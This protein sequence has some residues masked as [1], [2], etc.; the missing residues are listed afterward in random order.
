MNDD[1]EAEQFE[2]ELECDDEHL[3][4]QVD[5]TMQYHICTVPHQSTYSAGTSMCSTCS[6]LLGLSITSG[7]M[8]DPGS[9]T[10]AACAHFL[11][12]IMHKSS[13]MQR[14]HVQTGNN[15][16]MRQ[17]EEVVA[18]IKK[19]DTT[20]ALTIN[21]HIEC[22]GPLQH[23]AASESEMLDAAMGQ[24][25]PE[26]EH[27]I[28]GLDRLLADD[29][30]PGDGVV[31]TTGGHTTYIL[32]STSRDPLGFQFRWYL[33]DSLDG[34]MTC[35]MG[36]ASEVFQY[37]YGHTMD[38]TR[39]FTAMIMR[40]RA[41]PPSWLGAP[42]GPEVALG[43]LG[44]APLGTP[45]TKGAQ[46]WLGHGSTLLEKQTKPM[47]RGGP[48]PRHAK[49][50]EDATQALNSMQSYGVV[51]ALRIAAAPRGSNYINAFE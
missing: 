11:N 43:P 23:D 17:I 34:T 21:N 19:T 30:Q 47:S 29:I 26:P 18:M 10:P 37:K 50:M 36:E 33:F 12:A 39:M 3:V 20:G 24:S 27:I 32:H 51:Q 45:P 9:I 35:V 49:I 44:Q 16:E 2:L 28:K 48:G 7:L 42:R 4:N 38:G 40:A 6:T 8:P 15:E 41:P 14:D 13:L 22:F 5:S 25:G 1:E 46:P 31:V